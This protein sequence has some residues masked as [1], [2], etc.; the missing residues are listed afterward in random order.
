MES[1]RNQKKAKKKMKVIV[2]MPAYNAAQ[3]VEKT[4]NEIPK[5]YV[6]EIIL[7][8][9]YSKDNTVEVARKMGLKTIVHEKNKGYGGNQK[10]CYQNALKDGADVIIMLHPDYQYDPKAIPRILKKFEE[11]KADVVYGSRTYNKI[12][13]I[14]GGMPIW[15]IFGNST[16]NVMTNLVCG[17]HLTDVPT[18]YISYSRKVLETIP[19][20]RNS[21]G[22]TFDEE[23]I[24]QASACGFRLGEIPILTRYEKDSSSMQFMPSVKYGWSLFKSLL[25]FKLHKWGIKEHYLYKGI[26]LKRFG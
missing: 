14:K 26:K 12:S 21:D 24:I 4:Y 1:K 9:D 13:A 5:G 22:W 3:T 25:R 20:M 7:V 2:V 10:T 8:D 11:G 17:T 23:A 19:F 18:G 16:L 6:D 15:K